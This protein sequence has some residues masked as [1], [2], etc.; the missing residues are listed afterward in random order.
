MVHVQLISGIGATH[1]YAQKV[2]F[3]KLSALFAAPET[4]SA[5]LDSIC[6]GAF[7]GGVRYP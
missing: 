1:Q 7:T 6:N 2:A 4:P 3:L 5:G